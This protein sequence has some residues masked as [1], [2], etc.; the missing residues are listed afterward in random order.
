VPA[1]VINRE[2]A[3][4]WVERL[5]PIGGTEDQ[6]LAASGL[7]GL[8]DLAAG[9]TN[10]LKALFY[11][12][13]IDPDQPV[14]VAFTGGDKVAIKN[15]IDTVYF[16]SDGRPSIGKLVDTIEILKEVRRYNELFR[17]VFHAIAIGDFEKEFLRDLA[18]QNGGVYVDLGR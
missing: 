17:I 15:K 16:L 13:G 14:K 9:K 11:P 7:T 12:F 3:K 18:T 1:N 4:D 5:K 6:Q 10:T 8:T 2:S